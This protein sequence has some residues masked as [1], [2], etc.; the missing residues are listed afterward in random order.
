MVHPFTAAFLFI[1]SQSGYAGDLVLEDGEISGLPPSP[2][3]ETVISC[4][5]LIPASTAKLKLWK[6]EKVS[7][8]SPAVAKKLQTFVK[9]TKAL[10]ETDRQTVLTAVAKLI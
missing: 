5:Q 2:T 9:T 4:S 7:T 8:L 3:G 6:A 10:N 1:N